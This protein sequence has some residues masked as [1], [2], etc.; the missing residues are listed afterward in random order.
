V[1]ACTFSCSVA[2]VLMYHCPLDYTICFIQPL[3]QVTVY[4]SLC[5]LRKNGLHF[6]SGIYN[7]SLSDVLNNWNSVVSSK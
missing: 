5:E 3:F 2:S 4:L 7:N 1:D 6:R